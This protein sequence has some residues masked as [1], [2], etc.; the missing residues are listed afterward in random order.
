MAVA[1]Q[2]IEIYASIKDCLAVITDY[3][4]YPEFLKEV[5]EVKVEKKSPAATEV[6]YTLDLIKKFSYTLKMTP[7][8]PSKVTWTFVKGDVMKDNKGEWN[9]EEISPGVTK[10]TYS[11]DVSLGLLVP[12]AIAKML[13]GNNLPAMLKA[14]KERIESKSK[15]KKK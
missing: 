2:S 3:E 15:K 10:A 13:I 5:S 12:G 1:A 6:T 7:K 9:L 14:F 11:I 4:S 8:P